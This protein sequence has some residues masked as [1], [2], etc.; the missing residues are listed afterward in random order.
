MENKLFHF[1]LQ[2]FF[3]GGEEEKGEVGQNCILYAHKHILCITPW[4]KSDMQLYVF[5]TLFRIMK[6][7]AT[8]F[9]CEK[10]HGAAPI[11]DV[12]CNPLSLV[13]YSLDHG[14]LWFWSKVQFPKQ[15]DPDQGRLWLLYRLSDMDFITDRCCGVSSAKMWVARWIRCCTCIRRLFSGNFVSWFRCFAVI[16]LR[17][18][19]HITFESR[20][21][22]EE[23]GYSLMV[24]FKQRKLF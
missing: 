1:S 4:I 14:C 20:S 22:S 21:V 15:L 12:S 18:H 9:S 10:E 5:C 6:S 8:P 3:C 2:L 17:G 19:E 7:V 23:W 24:S 11:K 16:K 13:T